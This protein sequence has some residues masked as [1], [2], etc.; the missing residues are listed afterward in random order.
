MPS[1][2][3]QVSV[4]NVRPNDAPIFKAC[5]DHELPIV[6]H[7]LEIGEA[8]IHDVDE[9]GDGLPEVSD[10]CITRKLF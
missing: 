1:L 8:S 4:V 5:A 6:R 10:I 7:L 3:G 9:Y 2:S